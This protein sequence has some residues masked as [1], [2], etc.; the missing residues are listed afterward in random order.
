MKR[1]IV[2]LIRSYVP[3][4]IL[5]EADIDEIAATVL[6]V[7]GRAP[8]Y[9]GAGFRWFF[10]THF[11][12]P[13]PVWTLEKFLSGAGGA[14][15]RRM[16]HWTAQ[17]ILTI[18]LACLYGHPKALAALG[19]AEG[20]PIGPGS[21]TNPFPSIVETTD[22]ADLEDSAL[23]ADVVVIGSG[24]GGSTAALALAEAGYS[25]LVLES[26][27]RP[28]GRARP[29]PQAM[30][31]RYSWAGTLASM[32]PGPQFVPILTGEGVG[33]SAH[34][35]MGT[36]LRP[37]S[38]VIASWGLDPEALTPHFADAER[39]MGV[40]PADH[41]LMG[42]QNAV[43]RRGC[44]K[45]GLPWQA[46]PRNALN[47]DGAAVC[48]VGGERARKLSPERTLLPAAVRAGAR[49]VTRARV[50][51]IVPQASGSVL[52]YVDDPNGTRLVFARK[53]VGVAA[54]PI[55]TPLL[56]KRSGFRGRAIGRAEFFQ[57]NSN[58]LGQ[59]SAAVDSHVG[60][61]QG[62][63]CREWEEEGLVMESVS[64]PP[65]LIAPYLPGSG[66]RHWSQM[67]EFRAFCQLGFI[68]DA[69]RSPVTVRSLAGAPFLRHRLDRRDAERIR[70]GFRM[71]SDILF[72]GGA[73]RVLIPGQKSW[74]ES[75]LEARNRI[76]ETDD[77]DLHV[78]SVH[79][80]GTCR[81]GTEA[82]GAAVDL[83]GRLHEDPRIIVF[84]GSVLPTPLGVNPQLTIAAVARRNAFALAARLG[85]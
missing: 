44:E 70:K 10:R 20:E 64:T 7:L 4:G 63:V 6:T 78:V 35:N 37:A 17:G 66:A 59:L 24:P 31:D 53:A 58:V 52:V 54:G 16:E 14:R 33:G 40:R 19:L 82:G 43:M 69:I 23:S 51:R 60:I 71:A 41:A 9:M 25:V 76:D 15:A 32:G 2:K 27:S 50:R 11:L 47:R 42:G 48:M 77:K 26:G 73:W 55:G 75:P 36:S 56:L 22:I 30:L 5:T 39:R 45:L 13:N 85:K 21:D 81:M 67:R 49:V 29:L 84:D 12:A 62:I 61:E 1:A 38:S 46:I 68:A 65:A 8:W 18:V 74:C 83:D 72:A 34:V 3:D 79:L 80:I 57:L 28:D